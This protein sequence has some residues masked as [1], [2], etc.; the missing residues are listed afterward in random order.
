MRGSIK[1]IMQSRNKTQLA[2]AI[3]EHDTRESHNFLVGLGNGIWI[4]LLLTLVLH[5]LVQVIL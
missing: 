3:R 5:W 1:P 2:L 4:S